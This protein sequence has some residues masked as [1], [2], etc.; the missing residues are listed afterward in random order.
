MSRFRVFKKLSMGKKLIGGFM[1]ATMITAIVGGIGYFGINR[2]VAKINEV[3]T[4]DVV[5][6]QQALELKVLALQHRRFEKDFFLNIGNSEK[7]KKY[8]SK[9]K[10]A[11]GKAQQNMDGL[12]KLIAED[13]HLSTEVKQSIGQAQKA[14]LSYFEGFLA[15]TEQVLKDDKITP[16][17][18]NKM[19]KPFKDNIYKFESAIEVIVENSAEMF[20]QVA[21]QVDESG[22][23][24]T[25]LIVLFL[26]AGIIA[27]TAI[28]IT[29]SRM[30]TKPIT[31]SVR[32]AEQIAS[33]DF[34]RQLEI[35]RQDEIGTLVDALNG[36]G[37]RLKKMI[38][39]LVSGVDTL[40]A[41]ATE[42]TAIS[43]EMTQGAEQTSRRADT[44][45]AASEEMSTNMH[46]VASASEQAASNVNIVAASAEEMSATV[47]EIAQNSEKARSVTSDAVTNAHSASE[48][49]DELGSA[50]REIS[51]VT[52]VITEIS[53]QTNLLALNA[54]IEAARA[55]EAGKGFAVV[56]NEIKDLAGQTAQATHEIKSKI[57]GIQRSTTDTV[58]EIGQ[59]S[60]VVN[61]VNEIVNTIA[62]AVEEQ[63]ATTREIAGNVSQASVGIQEVNQNVSQSSTV[64]GEIA[65]DITDVNQTAGQIASSSSQV[66]LSACQLSELSEQ[67]NAMVAAFKI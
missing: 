47:N 53:E 21:A 19:M 55:G 44:V 4:Q 48:R 49:V 18:A 10:V 61:D 28:G 57:E 15:L 58:T 67:L 3:T 37:A 17:K 11:S 5:L 31:E 35:D 50:A 34:T 52:E 56:A 43:D 42:L 46:A 8:I 29:I 20:S 30:I 62:T 27:S 13:P 16:Q 63:S 59:I 38:G 26:I 23:K 6:L 32:F 60:K 40:T 39:D 54:T 25:K 1:L 12:V 45:A 2:S 14:Y 51:K 7:Q 64:A 36:M 33:G 22:S 65:R 66:N 9:F 41:S 24:A